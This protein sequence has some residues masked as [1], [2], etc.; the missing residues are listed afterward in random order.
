VEL[1]GEKLL[2]QRATDV[3]HPPNDLYAVRWLHGLHRIA[4]IIRYDLHSLG[5][6]I[7]LAPLDDVSVVKAQNE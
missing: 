3:D 6:V 5:G 4:G 1:R 2:P 7:L